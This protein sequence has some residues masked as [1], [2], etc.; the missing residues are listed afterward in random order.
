MPY[1]LTRVLF[2]KQAKEADTSEG[3]IC[4]WSKS[5]DDLGDNKDLSYPSLITQA[6]VWCMH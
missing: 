2:R 3:Q 4:G 5:A 1:E 6:Y